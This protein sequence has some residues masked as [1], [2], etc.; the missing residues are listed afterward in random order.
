MLSLPLWVACTTPPPDGPPAV[1]GPLDRAVV[2]Q[3]AT[4]FTLPGHDGQ[5]VT[6]SD[7]EG[8]VIVIDMSGFH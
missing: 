7:H 4:D 6:L 8:D 2:G 5:P 3:R 1:A